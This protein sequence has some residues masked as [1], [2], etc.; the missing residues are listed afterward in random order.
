[1]GKDKDR[2]SCTH[3]ISEIRFLVENSSRH[4]SFVKVDC[5]QNW[6]SHC[7]ANFARTAARTMV[8][9]GSGP[10]CA[11][12]ELNHDLVVSPIA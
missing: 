8:W 2:S 12:Q 1:M 9:R 6:V 10:D 11:F 7:L 3:L 4:I 5:L